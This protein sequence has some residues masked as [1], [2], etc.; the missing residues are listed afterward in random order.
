MYNDD[1]LRENETA[2]NTEPETETMTPEAEPEPVYSEPETAYYEPVPDEAPA[3][4]EPPRYTA[5]VRE[6]P[7][8]NSGWSEPR[9]ESA[10]S[11][12]RDVYSPGG[13]VT[14]SQTPAPAEKKEKKKKS[15]GFLK[16]AAI[17][18]A[19]AV[20][21]SAASYATVSV[22]TANQEKAPTQVVLGAER[23]VQD[24]DGELPSTVSSE[25]KSANAIYKDA[26]NYQVVGVNT[27]V[28]TT[29]IWGQT[30]ARAVSGSGFVI[31]TDGYIMTNYHVISYAVRYGGELTVMFEDGTSINAE[32]IVGYSEENDVAV[33]KIDASELTLNPVAFG[34]SD[35]LQVGETVYAI[36]NPLGELTYSMTPGIVSALDR[37]IT[38]QDEDTGSY[39]SI[40]MFQIS[41]A[42]N[43]GNSGGPVY[44]SNGEVVGIVTAKYSDE[45]VEG[46]GFAIPINDAIDIA[47]QLIEKGYVTGASIGIM[48]RYDVDTYYQ[49]SVINTY[50]IP[51]GVIV[52]SVIEGSAAEKAGVKAGDIITGI[53]GQSAS[54]LDE[55]RMI[56]RKLNPG[57]AG[58][59]S[60]YRMSGAIGQGESLELDIVFDENTN[61]SAVTDSDLRDGNGQSAPTNPGQSWEDYFGFGR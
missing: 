25:T 12:E 34:D 57:D 23:T 24:T 55:L 13:A 52:D 19:C 60:I 38:T 32:K 51:N 8:S 46:L 7:V 15:H 54:G 22:M 48:T 11:A 1:E 49:A 17:V 35:A 50:G 29:N 2:Q 37:V 47:K 31:S 44:N 53:N 20:A 39:K 9:Y 33:I 26:C 3:F 40:N 27:S 56:L 45:G 42:V 14:Y 18:L 41:A 5:P 28:N 10:A 58:K 16:A 61:Q 59:I 21:S 30:T 6:Y 36:G 4:S 43:S